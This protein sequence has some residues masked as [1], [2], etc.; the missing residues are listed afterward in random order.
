MYGSLLR[1]YPTNGYTLAN[2]AR[3]YRNI[4]DDVR[5]ESAYRLGMTV[6]PNVS[7]NFVNLGSMLKKQ[8][9]FNEAEKVRV[10]NSL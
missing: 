10:F 5:A 9:R 8:Q 6:A 4:G 7:I 1:L 2:L 3:E